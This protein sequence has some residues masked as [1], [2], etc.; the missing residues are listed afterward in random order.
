M[1]MPG[2]SSSQSRQS[3]GVGPREQYNFNEQRRDSCSQGIFIHSCKATVE[4][5]SRKSTGWWALGKPDCTLL[6]QSLGREDL[7]EME[8]AIYSSILAWKMPWTEEPNSLQSMGSQ[9]VGHPL[10]QGHSLLSSTQGAAVPGHHD[11]GT[12]VQPCRES[13]SS[14]QFWAC[15]WQLCD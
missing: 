13:P 4:V 12:Q 8:M 9:R 15:C 1:P 14:Q 10:A 11:P 3:L 5:R 7:L 6:G 2:S